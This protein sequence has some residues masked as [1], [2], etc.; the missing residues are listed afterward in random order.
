MGLESWMEDFCVGSD[1]LLIVPGQEMRHMGV[2][3]SNMAMCFEGVVGC[4]IEGSARLRGGGG[5]GE[6]GGLVR[7]LNL[8]CCIV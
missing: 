4:G 7:G 6:G 2:P 8:G 5:L 1:H 3:C